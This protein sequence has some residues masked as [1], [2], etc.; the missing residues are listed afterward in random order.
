M[1]HF[2]TAIDAKHSIS[3]DD[4]R[5]V[6][7][8]GGIRSPKAPVPHDALLRLKEVLRMIPVGKS[9]WYDGID[10]GIYPPA[11]RLGSR[12]VAWRLSDI[13][14]VIAGAWQARDSE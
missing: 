7:K 10:K 13:N 2:T 14:L 1:S 11:I 8:S 12:T 4:I 5:S 9:S 3:E 6:D